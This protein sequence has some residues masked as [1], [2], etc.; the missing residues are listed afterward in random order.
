MS[1]AFHVFK[2]APVCLR[3]FIKMSQGKL[4]GLQ[5]RQRNP[6]QFT[7]LSRQ[8]ASACS[9]SKSSNYSQSSG[10]DDMKLRGQKIE[11]LSG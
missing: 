5:H 1:K 2:P 11:R 6:N 10:C 8:R 3:F 9:M 7:N 4:V